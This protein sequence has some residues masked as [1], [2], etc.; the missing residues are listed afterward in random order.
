MS[1]KRKRD[2][3][4]CSGPYFP[5][6]VRSKIGDE[7]KKKTHC[8]SHAA[9]AATGEVHSFPKR[10]F[11]TTRRM[12][13]Q[14]KKPILPYF[15]V[16]WMSWLFFGRRRQRFSLFPWPHLVWPANAIKVLLDRESS[17]AGHKWHQKE[18]RGEETSCQWA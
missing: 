7:R 18:K 14:K 8:P 11:G 1:Q 9:E 10:P 12:G 3:R 4:Y 15:G 17:P 6:S 2:G 13:I 16:C 5:Y